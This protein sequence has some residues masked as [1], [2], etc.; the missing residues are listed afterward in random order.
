VLTPNNKCA[1]KTEFMQIHR[2]RC[3]T[4]TVAVFID[5]HRIAAQNGAQVAKSWV[6]GVK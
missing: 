5:M 1:A 4:Q 6:K 2:G 3:K